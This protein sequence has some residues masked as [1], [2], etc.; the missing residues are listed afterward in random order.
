M[1]KD[2]CHVSSLLFLIFLPIIILFGYVFVNF[3]HKT[4]MINEYYDS[5]KEALDVYNGTRAD[6]ILYNYTDLDTFTMLYRSDDD[7]YL[8]DLNTKYDNGEMKY[9]CASIINLD[10]L[11]VCND[12][13]SITDFIN[14]NSFSLI[15]KLL[16][17][18]EVYF[19]SDN[20]D[21]VLINN[22]L[23]DHVIDYYDKGKKHFLHLFF[24]LDRI[25]GQYI[26]N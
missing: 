14:S 18:G 5:Y 24:N 21:K 1:L 4:R 22:K 13:D 23:P 7:L 26:L 9:Q 25:N 12:K 3:Y 16:G 20:D 6:E 15:H 8:A 17:R 19:I 10:K 11:P 2:F